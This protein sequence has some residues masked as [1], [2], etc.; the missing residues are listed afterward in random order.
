MLQD[1]H[2]ESLL[3]EPIAIFLLNPVKGDENIDVRFRRPVT[4]YRGTVQPDTADTCIE[5]LADNESIRC[6]QGSRPREI[7]FLRNSVHD[8]VHPVS[9][10]ALDF[11]EV[12]LL[13]RRGRNPGM[14]GK[15]PSWEGE[16]R[17][18]G[19]IRIRIRI[20]IRMGRGGEGN[21]EMREER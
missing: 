2:S 12:N 1:S 21:Y 20:M 6:C 15:C 14:R 16:G 17:E 4:A 8:C 11:Y 7:P 13:S 9:I 19:G 10:M 3:R 5:V 18:K